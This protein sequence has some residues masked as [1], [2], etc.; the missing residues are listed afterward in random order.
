[1]ELELNQQIYNYLYKYKIKTS[2]MNSN[3]L[4]VIALIS[5]TSAQDELNYGYS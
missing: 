1:M 2:N 4:A 3:K 5:A